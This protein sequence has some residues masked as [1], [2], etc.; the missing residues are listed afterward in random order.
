MVK[1]LCK[2]D[3][4]TYRQVVKLFLENKELKDKGFK[5]RLFNALRKSGV[6]GWGYG[7]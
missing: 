6:N 1:N 7:Y 3:G 4:K 5:K 2:Q